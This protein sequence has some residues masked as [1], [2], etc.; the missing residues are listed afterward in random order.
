[1]KQENLGAP[2]AFF[3]LEIS[4]VT[5]KQMDASFDCN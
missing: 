3:S 4:A 2:K 1:M 5:S